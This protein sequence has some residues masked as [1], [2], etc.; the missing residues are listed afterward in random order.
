MCSWFTTIMGHRGLSSTQADEK[1]RL[2]T[3]DRA[4]QFASLIAK[5]GEDSQ[6]GRE[7]LAERQAAGGSKDV[8]EE[9]LRHHVVASIE[10]ALRGPLASYVRRDPGQ[11][12][13]GISD[14]DDAAAH[15]QGFDDGSGL[16][17]ASGALLAM[18]VQLGLLNLSWQARLGIG[19]KPSL[20]GAFRLA[21]AARG[22]EIDPVLAA[23]LRFYLVQQRIYGLSAMRIPRLRKDEH[24]DN[25]RVFGHVAIM[26]VFAHEAAH[27]VLGHDIGGGASTITGRS[28][29]FEADAF[30]LLVVQVALSLEV[31]PQTSRL[32]LI[33]ALVALLATHISEK[34]LFVRPTHTHPPARERMHA[35][36]RGQTQGAQG[37]LTVMHGLIQATECASEIHRPI[38]QE[39][40]NQLRREVH[41]QFLVDGDKDPFIQ[42]AIFDRWRGQSVDAYKKYLQVEE[43]S[44][45]SVFMG[46]L[47][48][49][50]AGNITIAL[51]TLGL[52]PRQIDRLIGVGKGLAFNTLMQAIVSSPALSTLGRDRRL[53]FAITFSYCLETTVLGISND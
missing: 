44:N 30:A 50:E 17:V 48:Q 3:S 1:L 27:F 6:V 45:T 18:C 8:P 29:E 32:P 35:L 26:F 40:W 23:S 16:V 38:P 28:A 51:A 49:L 14:E 39:W 15:V 21:K 25:A 19:A 52:Q 10:Q 13:Y 37:I 7:L 5:L 11:L 20:L 24:E 22:S 34:A 46:V 12:R 47:S 33:G 4:A 2:L 9:Y 36:I 31:D 42:T 41:P 53:L 43:T